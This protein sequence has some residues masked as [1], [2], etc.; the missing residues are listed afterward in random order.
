MTHS[1]WTINIPY[2]AEVTEGMNTVDKIASVPI[3]EKDQPVDPEQA[4]I[5]SVRIEEG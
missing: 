3:N 4:R 5:K 2:L 1:F